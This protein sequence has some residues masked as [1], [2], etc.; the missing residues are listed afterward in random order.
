MHRLLLF[1]T[2][3]L[4][5][6]YGQD[7]AAAVENGLALGESLATIMESG[8]FGSS[9]SKLATSVG[10]YLGAIGPA[11]G[12][13]MAFT[14]DQ[15]DP[16]IEFMKTML[17]RIETRFDQIDEQFKQLTNQVNWN[18]YEIQL[19]KHES[20]IRTLSTNLGAVYKASASSRPGQIRSFIR[21]YDS[22]WKNDHEVLMTYTTDTGLFHENLIDMFKT[23][24]EN[25]C[26]KVQKFMLGLTDLILRG[27]SVELAYLEF[28]NETASY[29]KDRKTHWTEEIKKMKTFMSKV[30]KNLRSSKVYLDQMSKD[31]DKLL[32]NNK[33]VKDSDFATIAYS[34][35]MEKYN[36]RD[37]LV[38]SY[39]DIKGGNNHNVKACGGVLKFRTQ[40]RNLVIASVQRS[41]TPILKNSTSKM[42]AEK[43]LEDLKIH[44]TIKTGLFK[45][46]R[47]TEIKGAK[48]IYKTLPSIIRDKCSPYS[49]AGVIKTGS[50]TAFQAPPNRLLQKRKK[51]KNYGT[52]YD[53]FLFG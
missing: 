26:G 1:I 16:Q 20:T 47:R 15:S 19:S 25:H 40:K 7:T 4:A 52:K 22:N 33:G 39:D 46:G 32:T 23:Y 48:D 28:I 44:K 17:E 12:I 11:V 21:T 38:V 51:Y 50:K 41:R 5:F 3:L 24:T 14:G 45:Q 18:K 31:M 10:P 27:V 34:F 42:A 43:I 8:N 30:D 49:G 36:W 13:I 35:L 29:K 9:M 53:T 6:A 37:W 2:P